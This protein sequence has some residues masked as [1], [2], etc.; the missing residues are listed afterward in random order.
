[1]AN[2]NPL[3][4]VLGNLL[5]GQRQQ[6]IGQRDLEDKEARRS[7][8]AGKIA[9]LKAQFEASDDPS[10]RRR[11]AAELTTYGDPQSR[12][13]INEPITH[14]K[15]DR[16]ARVAKFPSS[17]T[18]AFKAGIITYEQAKA[19]GIGL[20]EA[21]DIVS[22]EE[23]KELVDVLPE[24]QQKFADPNGEIPAWRRYQ[25]FVELNNDV[26]S[27][28]ATELMGIGAKQK[29][30]PVYKQKI[31]DMMAILGPGRPLTETDESIL[32]ILGVSVGNVKRYRQLAVPPKLGELNGIARNLQKEVNSATAAY[33]PE[34]VDTFSRWAL[35]FPAR[36]DDERD[37]YEFFRGNYDK[38]GGASGDLVL[39]T[40]FDFLKIPHGRQLLMVRPSLQ[41]HL[42]AMFDAKYTADNLRE[43]YRTGKLFYTEAEYQSLLE[44]LESE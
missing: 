29:A 25:A 12:E 28:A 42:K 33:A 10:V 35:G 3:A 37:E 17:V 20:G 41:E 16:L 9:E 18:E 31:N 6:L 24:L 32:G 19:L 15:I 13:A 1:M 5:A 23:A 43:D 38:Q 21:P 39:D 34:Q 40:Y 36:N 2:A 11:I 27:S 44:A 30:V 8:R 14:Q 26:A 4:D 7:A 22:D